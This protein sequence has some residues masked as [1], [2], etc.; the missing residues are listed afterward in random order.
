MCQQNITLDIQLFLQA[1]VLEKSMELERLR[2]Q[3]ESL[4]KI[5]MEQLETI[6]HLTSN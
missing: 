2:V 3:Y 4:K 1:L 5:E 6:E